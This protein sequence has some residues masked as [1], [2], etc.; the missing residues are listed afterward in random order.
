MGEENVPENPPSRKFL[1]KRAS[2][3]LSRGFGLYRRNR[4][5]TPEGDGKRTRQRGVWEGCPS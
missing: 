1:D 2:D 4:A 3:L 5:M